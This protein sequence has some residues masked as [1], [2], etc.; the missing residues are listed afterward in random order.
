MESAITRRS[1]NG[2]QN[3]FSSLLTFLYSSFDVRTSEK[4]WILWGNRI[5]AMV[6]KVQSRETYEKRQKHSVK[7]LAR[8]ISLKCYKYLCF[9]SQRKPRQRTRPVCRTWLSCRLL[10]TVSRSLQDHGQ[11][12]LHFVPSIQPAID[13]QKRLRAAL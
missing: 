2:H 8:N 5:L 13:G 6:G 10:S 4:K 7:A 12:Q 3:F 1:T 11:V 9:L